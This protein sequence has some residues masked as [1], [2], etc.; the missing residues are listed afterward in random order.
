MIVM[1]DLHIGIFSGKLGKLGN[2]KMGVVEKLG[3]K[4]KN[5]WEK[6]G[7]LFLEN[8]VLSQQLAWLFPSLREVHFTVNSCEEVSFVFCII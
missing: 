7:S 2:L 6:L 5:D 8:Y 4:R 3:K 1:W